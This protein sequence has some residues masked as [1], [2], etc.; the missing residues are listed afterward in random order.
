M[1]NRAYQNANDTYKTRQTLLQRVKHQDDERSWDEF[2]GLYRPY[3]YVICQRMNLSHHD[4]EDISQQVLM[5]LWDKLPEFNY[6]DRRS[7]RAWIGTVTRNCANDFFRRKNRN[8]RTLEHSKNEGL[9]PRTVT[10]SEVEAI[11]KEEWMRY[12]VTLALKR[13]GEHFP[14]KAIQVFKEL[15]AGNHRTEIARRHNLTPDSV[16]A[17]KGRVLT[18]LC[19]EIRDI[20][21]WL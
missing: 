14:P 6:N 18:A 21:E 16:S 1:D 7:F 20:D 5:K 9:A 13:I 8:Q 15:Q 4:C 12:T 17:Y 11:A 10:E 3:I 19:A 2:V